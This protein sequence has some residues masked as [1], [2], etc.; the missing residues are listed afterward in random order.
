MGQALQQYGCT[1]VARARLGLMQDAGRVLHRQSGLGL[2]LTRLY[3]DGNAFGDEGCAHLTRALRQYACSK[4]TQLS[5][6]RNAIGNEACATLVRGLFEGRPA[7]QMLR[8]DSNRIDVLSDAL[9]QL[10]LLDTLLS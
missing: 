2:S 4:L 9:G 3:L 7:L 1:D 10:R 5:F 6:G 8:V